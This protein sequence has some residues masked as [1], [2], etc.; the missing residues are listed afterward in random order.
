M[1]GKVMVSDPGPRGEGVIPQGQTPS[2]QLGEGVRYY[3]DVHRTR[4]NGEG[5]RITFTSDGTTFRHVDSFLD[6]PAD[7][8]DRVFVDVLPLHH[9][10]GAIELLKRGVEVYYL[11]RT[12][13]IAKK[14]EELRLS[15]KSAKSDVKALMAIGDKWFRRVSED[16]LLMRRMIAGYRSLHKSHQQLVN[17]SKALS[18]YERDALKP[19]I[20]AIEE[21]MEILAK[22]IAEEAGK[23][24]PAYNEI[25]EELQIREASAME[26]LA[27]IILYLDDRGFRRTA[28]LFGLFKPARGGKK[29]Y[30]GRLRQALQRLTASVNGVSAFQVT[31]KLEKRM[32]FEVWKAHRRLAIPAQQG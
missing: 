18:E 30:D 19:A 21:Q 6:I 2:V 7:A 12:S 5:F 10:D 26:T 17:K 15:S 16:F 28:N 3:A 32:L 20:K 4:K 14:R 25:I 29:I 1:A 13:L 24:Y 22:Q 8:G 27:E 31:A 23:R 9:T 11:R